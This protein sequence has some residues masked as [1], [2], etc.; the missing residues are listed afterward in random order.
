MGIELGSNFEMNVI[1]CAHGSA[2][3]CFMAQLGASALKFEMPKSRLRRL[4]PDKGIET[5]AFDG[6]HTAPVCIAVPSLVCEVH[7]DGRAARQ[8]GSMLGRKTSC[9][10]ARRTVMSQISG[11]H[12]LV[13]RMIHVFNSTVILYVHIQSNPYLMLA[14]LSLRLNATSSTIWQPRTVS[15]NSSY[16]EPFIPANL[17]SI[18]PSMQRGHEPG[19][20]ANS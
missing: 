17:D 12:S 15:K 5:Y 4:G 14:S 18:L 3:A 20:R 13:R 16:Y 1:P 6:T 19:C 2:C 11:R 10:V 9:S 7:A 8:G